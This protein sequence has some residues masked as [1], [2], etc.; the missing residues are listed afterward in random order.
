LFDMRES[1]REREVAEQ[2]A[3]A[4]F[5]GLAHDTAGI[6]CKCATKACRRARTCRGDADECGAR[7]FPEGWAWIHGVLQA[8]RDGARP[9]AAM[10]GAARQVMAMEK[11]GAFGPRGGTVVVAYPGL[12]EAFDLVV[13][14]RGTRGR[15]AITP[16]QGPLRRLK[17]WG[18]P[19]GR[20]NEAIPRRS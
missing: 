17:G 8:L 19:G 4:D 16:Y 14:P 13:K 18:T 20:A 7:R 11:D 9:R 2:R 1:D 6:W 12:A 10:R 3:A 15:R 5:L